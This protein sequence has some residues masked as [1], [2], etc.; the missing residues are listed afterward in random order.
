MKKSD[1]NKLKNANAKAE[2]LF[3][4]FLGQM[5]KIALIIEESTGIKGNVDHLMGDDLG[6]TP[7]SNN[8]THM[9]V[10][11]IIKAAENGIE[12]TED[13]ILENLSI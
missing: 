12:I 5:E 4:Q 7:E 8:D 3:N 9:P 2:K 10:C 6:F 1:I 11:D 13:F